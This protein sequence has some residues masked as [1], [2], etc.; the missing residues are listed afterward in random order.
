[1]LIINTH[2]IEM[3]EFESLHSYSGISHFIT[4]RNGAVSGSSYSSFNMCDYVGDDPMSVEYCRQRMAR[5]LEIPVANL[6]FPRQ[7]HGDRIAVAEDL[8]LLD[9]CDALITNQ[10]HLCIG[11]STADCVPILL[12][13]PQKQVVGAV[14]AGWR[15]TVMHI[16][17]KTVRRMCE[18]Y[19][20]EPSGIVAG[21]G[22]SISSDSF[23]VGEEVAQAFR[24]AGFI[25]VGLRNNITGKPHIDLWEA[26]RQDLLQAGLISE[27]IEI[28]EICTY[29]NPSRL[30]SARREGIKSG[31]IASAIMLK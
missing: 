9:E 8:S 26:N 1:M 10:P 12:Y 27:K 7:V 20:C 15:G 19:G 2:S 28:A 16:A 31:R 22:P 13:S 30:F 3:L 21:I 29:K 5:Q 14:H 4:T 24:E 6:L 11:V 18:L 17:A 25:E 23:E